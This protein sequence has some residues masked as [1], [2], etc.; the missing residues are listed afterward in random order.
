MPSIIRK[1]EGSTTIG[2]TSG[3]SIIDIDNNWDLSRT[4]LIFGITCPSN[5]NLYG[6]NATVGNLYEESG[7]KKVKFEREFSG[8]VVVITINYTI[9]EMTNT[10][11]QHGYVDFPNGTTVKT[12]TITAVAVT[13]TFVLAGA[14]T[15]TYDA[16]ARDFFILTEVTNTTTIT[17]RRGQGSGDLHCH[18]Q[19]IEMSEITSLQTLSGTI[20]NTNAT[21][22]I[23]ITEVDLTKAILIPSYRITSANFDSDNNR[24][25]RLYNSTTIRFS[26]IYGISDGYIYYN[27]VV[28]E[29]PYI[30][31]LR[32][33]TTISS[34]DSTADVTHG[35][36]IDP[37]RSIVKIGGN[38]RTWCSA[39]YSSK[40]AADSCFRPSALTASQFTLT[41]GKSGVT[42]YV[43]WEVIEFPALSATVLDHPTGR[44]LSR[45]VIRGIN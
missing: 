39:N 31:V 23:T 5:Q 19:V 13:K 10:V 3:S 18:Y 11:V 45:G 38:A 28:I 2:S 12:A 24:T 14:S 29:L 26:A 20:S 22:D 37:N 34:G 42:A 21:L 17:L 15:E 41:R 44:G 25:I 35:G 7:T 30:N 32:A 33:Y 27:F 9:I 6:Y 4:F 1:L 8:T 16:W 40:N 43:P 36:T